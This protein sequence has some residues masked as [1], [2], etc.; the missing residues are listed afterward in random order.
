MA[1]DLNGS[2]AGVNNTITYTEGT[3][4]VSIAPTAR[5]GLGSTVANT[6]KWLTMK[7]TMQN[8]QAGDVWS[9]KSMPAG[10]VISLIAGGPALRLP[11]ELPISSHPTLYLSGT[12][13]T[14]DSAWQTALASVRYLDSGEVLPGEAARQIEL[15]ARNANALTSTL[16]VTVNMVPVNDAPVANPDSGSALEAGGVNNTTAGRPALGNV[17]LNDTDPD[18]AST[19]LR[20][21]SVSRSGVAVPAGTLIAGT[22]GFLV[23][24]ADGSYV[25]RVFDSLPAVQALRTNAQTLRE[26]FVYTVQDSAG[27]A[28]EASLTVTIVGSNDS[29]VAMADVGEAVEQGGPDSVRSAV[30]NVLAND[31]D[32]DAG[33]TLTVTSAALFGENLMAAGTALTGR[34]GTLTV[35]ANGEYAYVVDDTNPEVL[36]LAGPSDTLTEIF[37]YTARDLAGATRNA[38]LTLTVT[39]RNDAP[40]AQA[41]EAVAVEAGGWHNGTAGLDPSGNVLAN[42]RDP[43]VGDALAVTS[44]RF[45]TQASQAGQALQGAY[46]T[47]VL[48]A[49]GSYQYRVNQGNPAVE[50]LRTPSDTLTETFTYRVSD[51]AGAQSEATLTITLNGQDDTPAGIGFGPSFDGSSAGVVSLGDDP[52]VLRNFTL[53]F[54][55]TP[56]AEI[57]LHH[58]EGGHVDPLHSGQ[59]YTIAPQ[60]QASWPGPDH[61]SVGVSVG[62]NGVSVYADNGALTPLLTWEGAVTAQTRIAVVVQDNCPTLFVNGEA[63]RTGAPT[64][65]KLHPGTLLGGSSAHAEEGFVGGL[66]SVTLWDR[67]LAPGLVHWYDQH[68]AQ[69][70][71][72]GL[73]YEALSAVVSEAAGPGVVVAQAHT[74]DVDGGDNA[75]YSLVDDAGGR[76]VVDAATGAIRVAEG[77]H[78]DHE[79]ERG[80]S[81]RV[82]STDLSGQWTEQTLHIAVTDAN[83]APVSARGSATMTEDNQIRLRA[84]SL[85]VPAVTDTQGAS[86]LVRLDEVPPVEQGTL[87][88]NGV[89]M[90]AGSVIAATDVPRLSFQPRLFHAGAFEFADQDSGDAMSAVRVDS[91]PPPEQGQLTYQGQAVSAGLV[92]PV[93][94]LGDLSFVPARDFNGVVTFQY[95]VRDSHGAFQASPGTFELT[96]TPV[97]DTPVIAPVMSL[98]VQEGAT[99]RL[100]GLDFAD[101]DAGNEDMVLTLHVSEGSLSAGAAAGVVVQGSGSD[102][103]QL[104]GSL[105]AIQALVH[106]DTGIHFAAPH[107]EPPSL[108]TTLTRLDN[109]PKATDPL[110]RLVFTTQG[111]ELQAVAR[112]GVHVTS[113]G[114]NTLTIEGRASAVQA[115][116][117]DEK[118]VQRLVPHPMAELTVRLDDQGHTGADPGLTGTDFNEQDTRVIGLVLVPKGLPLAAPAPLPEGSNTSAGHN[119]GL[120]NTTLAGMAAGTPLVLAMGLQDRIRGLFGGGTADAA[121]AAEAR[122]ARAELGEALHRLYG[123]IR[124]RALQTAALAPAPETL[125]VVAGSLAV[126]ATIVVG[127][128]V[129]QHLASGN[130]SG[131]GTGG[132]GGTDTHTPPHVNE[133]PTLSA[134]AQLSGTEDTALRITGLVFNDTDAGDGTVRLTLSVPSGQGTLQAS[135]TA[136]VQVQGN[137]SHDITLLGTVTALQA[138]VNGP[139]GVVLQ[140]AANANGHVSLTVTLNDLGN[141]GTDPGTSGSDH[142]EERT[143]AIDLDIASVNDAPSGQDTQLTIVEGRSVVLTAAH[144]PL[145]DVDGDGLG[146]VRIDSLPGSGQLLLGDQPLVAGTWV[147]R[148]QLDAGALRYQSEA[149]REDADPSFSFTVED[150]GLQS[151]GAGLADPQPHVFTLDVLHT[152]RV[153][154]DGQH[155][156][157]SAIWRQDAN[158][159]LALFANARVIDIDQRGQTVAAIAIE[160]PHGRPGDRWYLDEAYPELYRNATGDW[161]AALEWTEDGPDRT[162]LRRTDGQSLTP[163]QAEALLHTIRYRNLLSAPDEVPREFRASV[164]TTDGETSPSAHLNLIVRSALGDALRVEAAH[165]QA[166]RDTL[167]GGPAQGN[168]P[169]EREALVGLLDAR[170]ALADSAC[171]ALVNARPREA[172]NVMVGDSLLQALA[173]LGIDAPLMLEKP[174]Q[175]LNQWLQQ[176]LPEGLVLRDPD[177]GVMWMNSTAQAQLLQRI[178]AALQEQRL[179]AWQEASLILD[180]ATPDPEHPGVLRLNHGDALLVHLNAKGIATPTATHTDT[181]AATWATDPNAW[182]ITSD[183]QLLLPQAAWRELS[184]AIELQRHADLNPNASDTELAF[185]ALNLV[186]GQGAAL[187]VSAELLERLA[188]AGVPHGPVREST[189]D[190]ARDLSEEGVLLRMPG[191]LLMSPA[192]RDALAA[193]LMD[194][195]IEHPT[196]KAFQPL[197]DL[198][199]HATPAN[200]PFYLPAHL[201]S[202][203]QATHFP[204]RWV[205]ELDAFSG[206][207]DATRDPQTGVIALSRHTVAALKLWLSTLDSLPPVSDPSDSMAPSDALAGLRALNASAGDSTEHPG[208]VAVHDA[209]VL[210]ALLRL[211]NI[212]P[213]PIDRYRTLGMDKALA[214]RFEA[215]DTP[216][217]DASQGVLYLPRALFAQLSQ[218]LQSELSRSVTPLSD[219]PLAL[220]PVA[221]PAP[222]LNPVHEQLK[223]AEADGLPTAVEAVLAWLHTG[224]ALNA[225]LGTT[226]PQWVDSA[227]LANAVALEGVSLPALLRSLAD[228]GIAAERLGPLSELTPAGLDTL[229]HGTS[230]ALAMNDQQQVVVGMA[231]WQALQQRLQ[232]QFF[233][234]KAQATEV[235]LHELMR[236][237]APDGV[238]VL[239]GQHLQVASSGDAVLQGLVALSPELLELLRQVGVALPTIDAGGPQLTDGQLQALRDAPGH[240]F[241]DSARG[242]VW[243]AQATLDALIHDAAA[244]MQAARATWRAT[245]PGAA[246]EAPPTEQV[247]AALQAAEGLPE[248]LVRVALSSSE[249]RALHLGF[250]PMG[251]FDGSPDA[252]A[253]LALSPRGTVQG[254]A[255][256]PGQLVMSAATR[257][258]LL[259]QHAT[260]QSLAP[261]LAFD[262]EQARQGFLAANRV[263]HVLAQ[264]DE[265]FLSGLMR[266]DDPADLLDQL[267]H[268]GL[269]VLPV[270]NIPP[271]QVP[272]DSPI[273]QAG[274]VASWN[275]HHF[276]S[277]AT[278]DAWQTAVAEKALALGG[279]VADA[280]SP[281]G[282]SLPANTAPESAGLAS[283][284]QYRELGHALQ[285]WVMDAVPSSV[286]ATD[287]G[288]TLWRLPTQAS[289]LS[290]QAVLHLLQSANPPITALGTI[291]TASP[292]S[293]DALLGQGLAW[294]RAPNGDILVSAASHEAIAQRWQQ[295]LTQARTEVLQDAI[296]L[297]VAGHQIDPASLP[298]GDDAPRVQPDAGPLGHTQLITALARLQ[299]WPAPVLQGS[300]ELVQALST[301]LQASSGRGLL[302]VGHGLTL[303]LDGTLATVHDGGAFLDNA[304]GRARLADLPLGSVQTAADGSRWMTPATAMLLLA[305]ADGLAA[306]ARGE[307]TTDA[308]GHAGEPLADAL[309]A[310]HA[311]RAMAGDTVDEASATVAPGWAAVFRDWVSVPGQGA[312][313]L[314]QLQALHLPCQTLTLGSD[315]ALANALSQGQLARPLT[316]VID[317]QGQHLLS[318]DTLRYLTEAL[319]LRVQEASGLDARFLGLPDGTGNIGK[320][321]V[322]DTPSDGSSSFV[323]DTQQLLALTCA[324]EPLDNHTVAVPVSAPALQAWLLRAADLGMNHT[325]VEIVG[326]AAGDGQV[327]FDGQARE[328][329]GTLH[330]TLPTAIALQDTLQRV[331]TTLELDSAQAMT[332]A[333][334]E[335]SRHRTAPLHTETMGGQLLALRANATVEAFLSRH[336]EV[337]RP[338]APDTDGHQR[339]IDLA[340][341]RATQAGY[342]AALAG[343]RGAD[344]LNTTIT[345]PLSAGQGNATFTQAALLATAQGL[346]TNDL[347][348]AQDSEGAWWM[349]ATTQQWLLREAAQDQWAARRELGQ[350]AFQALDDATPEQGLVTLHQPD[351]IPLLRALDIPVLQVNEA[352]ALSA[353]N[354]YRVLPDGGVQ[355]ST[356]TREALV[357]AADAAMSGDDQAMHR[358][359][360]ALHT[361]Q[362]IADEVDYLVQRSDATPLA[363]RATSA[364]DPAGVAVL[365]IAL[366]PGT[367]QAWQARQWLPGA[368][369]QLNPNDPAERDHLNQL[370]EAGKAFVHTTADG[371]ERLLVS[372]STWQA[373]VDR[374]ATA[375]PATAHPL[376]MLPDAQALQALCEAG[377]PLVP[378]HALVQRGQAVA[379]FT[380]ASALAQA[381]QDSPVGTVYQDAEGRAWMSPAT[382]R[383]A[384]AMVQALAHGAN[385]PEA[386]SS[387]MNLQAQLSAY[388][389]LVDLLAHANTTNSAALSAQLWSAE[390]HQHLQALGIDLQR[391][392]TGRH[393]TRLNPDELLRLRQA[394]ELA[395]RSAEASLYQREWRAIDYTDA[396]GQAQRV[397]QLDDPDGLLA[398]ALQRAHLSLG[399]PGNLTAGD[400][401]SQLSPG[402]CR[403]DARGRLT[404]GD[405]TH[406]ALATSLELSALENKAALHQSLRAA[407]LDARLEATEALVIVHDPEAVQALTQD[408]RLHPLGNLTDTLQL[409]AQQR[410]ALVN[411]TIGVGYYLTPE[412]D[413]VMQAADLQALRN[414]TAYA[415]SVPDSAIQAL[416]PPPT[417][418][419]VN[420]AH[421]AGLLPHIGHPLGQLLDDEGHPIDPTQLT[422]EALSDAQR[423][424]FTQRPGLIV[425]GG[426]GELLMSADTWAELTA[427]LTRDAASAQAQLA[428][429]LQ[430]GLSTDAEHLGELVTL[431][432]NGR[433]WTEA[434]AALGLSPDVIALPT[435]AS[436]QTNTDLLAD[437]LVVGMDAQGRLVMSTDTHQWLQSATR[438]QAWLRGL[439]NQGSALQGDFRALTPT[440][441]TDGFI[442]KPSM[443]AVAGYGLRAV[444]MQ[445]TAMRTHLNT[446]MAPDT[447]LAENV[448]QAIQRMVDYLVSDQLKPEKAGRLGNI[449][450]LRHYLALNAPTNLDEV[451]NLHGLQLDPTTHHIRSLPSD[452]GDLKHD[453]DDLHQKATDSIERMIDSLYSLQQ[454]A[455]PGQRA[456]I[457]NTEQA[458]Y[459]EVVSDITELAQTLNS[460]FA[461][462][463]PT[464]NPDLP[465]LQG[466]SRAEVDA[467]IS[468]LDA[469]YRPDNPQAARLPG[470]LNQWIQSFTQHLLKLTNKVEQVEAFED[471]VEALS[472]ELLATVTT[473]LKATDQVRMALETK[474]LMNGLQAIRLITGVT[475]LALYVPGLVADAVVHQHMADLVYAGT[476]KGEQWRDLYHSRSISAYVQAGAGVTSAMHPV[477][478]LVNSAAD[479][480]PKW[481]GAVLRAWDFPENRNPWWPFRQSDDLVDLALKW[482]AKAAADKKL[483]GGLCTQANLLHPIAFMV[484]DVMS[485]ATSLTGLALNQYEFR[486]IGQ[487]MWLRHGTGLVSGL[488]SLVA[489]LTGT[490]LPVWCLTAND[491]LTPTGGVARA[492]A[493]QGLANGLG[494]S[495][496]AA[497]Q[498][499]AIPLMDVLGHSITYGLYGPESGASPYTIFD[500]AL[501]LTIQWGT[502]LAFPAMGSWALPSML[503]TNL[504]RVDSASV[505]N[506][507]NGRQ[508]HQQL[509]DEGR[510]VEAGV[511]YEQ[512][513]RDAFRATPYLNWFSGWMQAGDLIAGTLPGQDLNFADFQQAVRERVAAQE[514][515][516]TALS[517]A[518]L[519]MAKA[520]EAQENYHFITGRLDDFPY[521]VN[522]NF[523]VIQSAQVSHVV[524][525]IADTTHDS[526]FNDEKDLVTDPSQADHYANLA[527]IRVALANTTGALATY[528]VNSP[529]QVTL[530]DI[531]LPVN[532]PFIELDTRGSSADSVNRV[533]VMDPR[534]LVRGGAATDVYLLGQELTPVLNADGWMVGGYIV[535]G[536]HSPG[537]DVVSFGLAGATGADGTGAQLGYHIHT[538]TNY[539]G[540]VTYQGIQQFVGSGFADRFTRYGASGPSDTWVSVNAGGGWDKVDMRSGNNQVVIG[541]GSVHFNLDSAVSAASMALSSIDLTTQRAEGPFASNSQAYDALYANH[542]TAQNTN[543]VTLVQEA[544]ALG[545]PAATL[546]VYGNALAQDVIDAHELNGPIEVTALTDGQTRV[547][548]PGG[549]SS[550][551]LEVTLDG[552]VDSLIGTLGADLFVFDQATGIRQVAGMGG[553]DTFRINTAGMTVLAGDGRTLIELGS[554]ALNT[555]L[556]LGDG[557]QATLHVKAPIAPSNADAPAAKV[558]AVIDGGSHNTRIDASDS[559][560]ELHVKAV[561]GWG[562]I[563]MGGITR[564][565][566]GQDMDR[567]EI[568]CGQHA[569][570]KELVIE[571]GDPDFQFDQLF[572]AD[573]Q[574]GKFLK[575]TVNGQEIYETRWYHAWG[576]YTELRYVGD[577]F[578][579]V[580]ISAVNGAISRPLDDLVATPLAHA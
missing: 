265:D 97:N 240:G 285:A 390:S 106:G 349:S 27:A 330:M 491:C 194:R 548:Q 48:N 86:A 468:T 245:D 496:S 577:E 343:A 58:N 120:D 321:T 436:A 136:S 304:L 425:Q 33:D 187:L 421:L 150:D 571:M 109:D 410:E 68:P 161:P 344:F 183:G 476:E 270:E 357:R 576:G 53:A 483:T 16:G 35:A 319:T 340:T 528:H 376:V 95:S 419:S 56:L 534:T 423:L 143:V 233:R 237:E 218:T 378:V 130:D 84:T 552:Q 36:A 293:V 474:Q 441:A 242:L 543:V 74:W 391:D 96:I 126:G 297:L 219:T 289:G 320:R 11:V 250:W 353:P 444:Y 433:T 370:H 482:G 579:N 516:P 532:G 306:V 380:D 100:S 107:H 142:D 371:Q 372:E 158:T 118:A 144:F 79:T 448:D 166:L 121:E 324:P 395:G 439:E 515:H 466:I 399:T 294:G 47:L 277:Q 76:F 201:L 484:N 292:A 517:K 523:R 404:I 550:P 256:H 299:D 551:A 309:R 537:R 81:V 413:L 383:Q 456:V 42:D 398:Q 573:G 402:T 440:T 291:D 178:G 62:T 311:L 298:V 538:G 38:T 10:V 82:R 138:F 12:L 403:V 159:D 133:R 447:M 180:A 521:G 363:Q 272:A 478:L 91:L 499:T 502:I 77:A 427:Q 435:G 172:G 337:G 14:P 426:E 565:T 101:V 479:T 49:D 18:N 115:Y 545:A 141:T 112:E 510:E 406:Q 279:S 268:L 163:A 171:Q 193:E 348:V 325:V 522:P 342:E 459:L 98:D 181:P 315:A 480:W 556:F 428:L 267:R 359:A 167:T 356:S 127:S 458:H 151:H 73:L 189:G 223:H 65:M 513:W 252:M 255:S 9:I 412:G 411:G 165:E 281:H 63:V 85:G 39:G 152:L 442:G 225:L 396:Q 365:S 124:F 316:V 431:E 326:S 305:E 57:V 498:T 51:R 78:F 520:L 381:L 7:L 536:T 228:A 1:I 214:E 366:P 434:L 526:F 23:I 19:S 295:A 313:L 563:E 145:T 257:D 570:W 486:P 430:Q 527:P 301:Q 355:V 175:L 375:Q 54:S 472:D 514:V 28:S 470:D 296:R 202:Q 369:E 407:L 541:R 509:L 300:A 155:N 102:T 212:E 210:Q 452:L 146:R 574:Q 569:E 72:P 139:S 249:L 185:Q 37:V 562:T 129:V 44:V 184:T 283:I 462:L 188:R 264:A 207:G 288:H 501:F 373:L 473:D 508:M 451:F 213:E 400:L 241:H 286:Q 246:P 318:A 243:V 196:E 24:Q 511:V 367:L 251:R 21:T 338:Q 244:Q 322:H 335:A 247:V 422:A 6:D 25:Y 50:A 553:D 206:P 358:A 495:F 122:A 170:S 75:T 179:L 22:Y 192:T 52:G 263:E 524:N 99:T 464:L 539:Q 43:D 87:W 530:K 93:D 429:S 287:G 341:L 488:S 397:W 302:R 8:A 61:A 222:E 310:L 148:E 83:D 415:V 487:Y 66:E 67:A 140:P 566:V 157:G 558:A 200:D 229:V 463:N 211:A 190:D 500:S 475:N 282:L 116:V 546:H 303:P 518:V 231:P 198:L 248:G 40:Q 153:R 420:A 209:P 132:G 45:G 333:L 323:A 20:V 276:V 104:R 80:V 327:L 204:V 385:T 169:S 176:P 368:L 460:H 450:A 55:A 260:L 449:E 485:L 507:W 221:L 388:D 90:T 446:R 71:T 26:S 405:A 177:M 567:L 111:G 490:G 568:H 307:G 123:D 220:A 30:G 336:P 580:D 384:Q 208:M 332:E 339:P 254:D 236:A 505:V 386:D 70:G 117:D 128:V 374:L 519:E 471:R 4:A 162:L 60:R 542:F 205:S 578:D 461:E 266:L 108:S 512:Y 217:L 346:A 92:V 88:L 525:G 110:V 262:P 453:L 164:I 329:N 572:T 227:L 137:H 59:R 382:A 119:A 360:N 41:D 392:I 492:W 258:W 174:G 46:G 493:G 273:F 131:T 195:L 351:L 364:D 226:T 156:E 561:D 284:E 290:E 235:L 409:N 557:N 314:A 408:A 352:D 401:A 13:A 503:L 3:S 114:T 416:T 32:V 232:A 424:Q 168:G 69:T 312:E 275:G 317:A 149:G 560:A 564:V 437:R 540:L 494:L 105:Q 280:L 186:W 328:V 544:T 467:L 347:V 261:A 438:A 15:V 160:T 2:L 182:V 31:R 535:D 393:D 89:A 94:Q 135:A 29:P 215:A 308:S 259:A 350:Q 361:A 173:E 345:L 64:W 239:V 278:L 274:A 269:T 554:E 271:A 216:L 531:N 555:E 417:M 547:R 199:A 147:K 134:P 454:Q 465:P 331:A 377:A 253:A 533:I 489:D 113:S 387:P 234:E 559:S 191:G 477:A 224:H 549:N 34:Y 5:V 497:I 103:L 529:V 457:P 443:A 469:L 418:V 504:L 394:V 197:R 203:L 414:S 481:K 17:L 389:A 354:T 362:L 455:S 125:A 445:A 230:L 379:N 334:L 154:V 575:T 432:G 238:A 506:A